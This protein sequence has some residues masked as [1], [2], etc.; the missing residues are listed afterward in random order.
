M[1]QRQ[2]GGP[3]HAGAA[4]RPAVWIF[5]RFDANVIGMVLGCGGNWS[6]PIHFDL[7]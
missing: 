3:P 1:E 4:R 5:W 6:I 7:F 2:D